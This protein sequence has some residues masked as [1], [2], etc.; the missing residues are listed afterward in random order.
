M[1]PSFLSIFLGTLGSPATLQI[2]TTIPDIS[3]LDVV[4]I[5]VQG[6]FVSTTGEVVIGSPSHLTVLNLRR[7][8]SGQ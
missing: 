3:P 2:S 7:V 5:A 8:G 4:T 6:V 1:A